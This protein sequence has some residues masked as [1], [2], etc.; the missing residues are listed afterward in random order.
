M[1]DISFFGLCASYINFLS[2]RFKCS[3]NPLNCQML[4]FCYEQIPNVTEKKQEKRLCSSV[5]CSKLFYIS[6][7]EIIIQWETFEQFCN[8]FLY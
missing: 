5:L 8:Q 2:L 3:E 4:L 1:E 6:E 7:T